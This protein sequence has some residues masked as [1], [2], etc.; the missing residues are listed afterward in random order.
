[1]AGDHDAGTRQA[2]GVLTAFIADE[3][4]PA[5]ANQQFQAAADNLAHSHSLDGAI[6][7][8][9]GSFALSVELLH[10]QA[11]QTG[12][13]RSEILQRIALRLADCG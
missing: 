1:M 7:L 4:G 12:E 10:D 9:V 11:Q 2:L 13:D 5:F 8:L 3:D 6:R